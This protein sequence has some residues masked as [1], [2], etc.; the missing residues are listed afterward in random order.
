MSE[1]YR[2]RASTPQG[3][4]LE[5]VLEA[6]SR[7]Q[8]LDEL[9]GRQLFPVTVEAAPEPSRRSRRLVGRRAAVT[10]WAR[11]TATLLDA[12]LP[13]DRALAVTAEHAAHDGLAEVLKE[14][15]SAVQ[16]GAGL[17]ESLA[18][19]PRY[20]PP[21]LVAM[22]EAGEASGVL[23]MV[24]EQA[25]QHLEESTELRSQIQSAL[26]YPALMAVVA[27][28]GVAVLL[29]FVVPRFSAMLEEV[30]SRLP[31][32]TRLLVGG[33]ELL[34]GWW[35]LWLAL[36]VLAVY[37]VYRAMGDPATRRRW[38]ATRLRLP[39]SGDL[40]M[41]YATAR[42]ARTLGI[43][44]KSGVAIV[45]AL[46]IARGAVSNRVVAEGV[47]RAATA[48]AEGSALAPALAGTLPPLALQ[49]VAVGEESGR[50]E[51]LCLRVAN[52]YDSQVR[53]ALRT[54][55]S[56]IEPAMI[57]IFGALVGFVALAMLQAIYS[58]NTTAF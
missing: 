44:L 35:W 19:H 1:R 4:I 42:F 48:V 37:G 8:A 29:L 27:S 11:D 41:K 55:V 36:A 10:L 16:S 3:Q 23:E 57:L 56:M 45:P 17:A 54:L 21:V 52:T 6:P 5:G 53:R 12:G 18:R 38:H 26:L 40:E 39:W 34:V 13:L 58:I 2:Y 43:L 47:A 7:N 50:L 49:M 25:A 31:L 32:T 9:R 28:I 30:G 51:D 46:R 14:V 15:R 24:F 20:F 22:V 33:S